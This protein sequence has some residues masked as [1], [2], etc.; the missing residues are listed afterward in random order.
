MKGSLEQALWDVN[1]HPG[2]QFEQ[3]HK[4]GTTLQNRFWKSMPHT[5]PEK[6][7][8]DGCYFNEK[9][10]EELYEMIRRDEIN[11]WNNYLE[12]VDTKS[13]VKLLRLWEEKMGSLNIEIKGNRLISNRTPEVIWNQRY[14]GNSGGCL[15][16]NLVFNFFAEKSQLPSKLV[17]MLLPDEMKRAARGN[18]QGHWMTKVQIQNNWPLFEVKWQWN[19][20]YK[21]RYADCYFGVVTPMHHSTKEAY[22]PVTNNGIFTKDEPISSD[23]IGHPKLEDFRIDKAI[24]FANNFLNES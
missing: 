14:L 16:F 22:V 11:Y 20:K 10:L 3:V 12:T 13:P 23:N 9:N 8:R 18:L 21:Q 5:L 2:K 19:P 7:I 6:H 1:A 4:I 15:P 24:E 17:Y